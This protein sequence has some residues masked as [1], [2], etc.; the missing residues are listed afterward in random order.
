MNSISLDINNNKMS[1]NHHRLIHT[2]IYIIQSQLQNINE[3]YFLH[4][5]IF[6]FFAEIQ[7]LSLV[8]NISHNMFTEMLYQKRHILSKNSLI[9]TYRELLN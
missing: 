6:I 5:T 4:R 2:L 7:R 9:E 3:Y 1:L 8:S